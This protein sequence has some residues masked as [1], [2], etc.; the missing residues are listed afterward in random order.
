MTDFAKSLKAL[1]QASEAIQRIEGQVKDSNFDWSLLFPEK[2]ELHLGWLIGSI[3]IFI[4]ICIVAIYLNTKNQDL[5][6]VVFGACLL[7]ATWVGVCVHLAYQFGC[8]F[9]IDYYDASY[10]SNNN[11]RARCHKNNDSN[12]R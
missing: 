7:C 1:G 8:C 5:F 10:E 9:C 11:T 4:L 3:G 12:F 6:L 2:K